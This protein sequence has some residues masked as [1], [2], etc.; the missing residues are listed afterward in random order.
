[1]IEATLLEQIMIAAGMGLIGAV[2]F[3]AIGL[4]SG[5]D[6][7]TTLAPLTLLVVLLG[8]PAAGVFTFFL[9]GAI[10][11]HMTHAIPTA[12]LGIPGDSLATPMLQDANI[13]RRLGVPHI[14][15]RKMISGAIVAAFIAVPVAVLF[16]VMLAP[17]GPSITKAAPWIFLVAALL[18]A[19]FS[20]GRW[21]SVVA[22]VPFVLLIVALQS[23]T[24][25]HGT[26]LSISYFLGIAIGPLV[27]DLFSLLSPVERVHMR[28]DRMRTFSLAPDVKSWKGYFPNPLKVLDREQT[29]WTIGT[30]IVS[31]ATFVFSPLAMTVVLGEV[32]SSR[33]KNAYHRLTTTLSARNG[34]TEST[35][36]AEALIPLIAFGLPLS[37]V[38]AGPAAPLFNAPPRFTIDAVTGE[39]HNLHNL[40]NNWEFLGYGLLSV[41]LAA[42]ISYPF[43]MNYARV[44]ALFVSKKVSH[45]AIISTF[46]GLIVVISFW[47][48]GGLGVLVILAM[49][50]VGGL[51]T[52]M[53]GFN[54][55]VQFMGYYTAVLSVPAILKLIS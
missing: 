49:G 44:A 7:T 19:Y 35:Y 10:A 27:A 23:L 13:L 51:L 15:L 4:I 2:V 6:E 8:V 31:S 16:A 18:I 46:I 55:G 3:A 29:K 28:R 9:A 26:K 41:I 1:M 22:L 20:A 42:L 30:A 33:I 36:I 32:V 14:A 11:K 52:R 54:S 5:S 37:P 39:T 45:E 21:A 50:L 40:L 34:V 24:A 17:F 48:G 25:M 38:A 53:I 12:L 47:E 43:A